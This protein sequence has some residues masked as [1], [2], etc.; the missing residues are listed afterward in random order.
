MVRNGY[1]KL[2]RTL[3]QLEDSTEND[4]TYIGSGGWNWKAQLTMV[5]DNEATCNG[6]LPS[7][8]CNTMKQATELQRTLLQLEDSTEND[9]TYI[10][11]GG[12][13]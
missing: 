12:W 1:S 7:E 10:G 5:R 4:A 9:A 3:L 13:N 8:L 11:S 6:G 2:Q